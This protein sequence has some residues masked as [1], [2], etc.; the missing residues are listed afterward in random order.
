MAETIEIFAHDVSIHPCEDAES[1]LVISG[2]GWEGEPFELY[3]NEEEAAT[4]LW[5]LNFYISS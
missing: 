1:V 5:Q 3:V 2:K 4:L